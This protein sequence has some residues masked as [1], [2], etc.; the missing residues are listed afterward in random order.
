MNPHL[1]AN[2]QSWLTTARESHK[3]KVADVVGVVAMATALGAKREA[4]L[5]SIAEGLKLTPSQVSRFSAIARGIVRRAEDDA[6]YSDFVRHEEAGGVS[7]IDAVKKWYKT[8]GV[9]PEPAII[10]VVEDTLGRLGATDP[11]TFEGWGEFSGDY[12]A[13]K[14]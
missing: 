12:P 4:E 13:D 9:R 2:I 1:E 10:K 8:D 6:N 5:K 3:W 14:I 7:Y 11:R